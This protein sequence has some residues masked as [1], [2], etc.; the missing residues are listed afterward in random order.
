MKG[1]D[2]VIFIL[3]RYFKGCCSN[4]R[5]WKIAI[6][7]FCIRAIIWVWWWCAPH[8]PDAQSSP[9]SEKP[10]KAL[11]ANSSSHS[12]NFEETI[13][14]HQYTD[15]RG[16]WGEIFRSFSAFSENISLN[17]VL[18]ERK[19]RSQYSAI[20]RIIHNIVGNIILDD[21]GD[22]CGATRAKLIFQHTRLRDIAETQ[23]HKKNPGVFGSSENVDV[24]AIEKI[25]YNHFHAFHCRI[26]DPCRSTVY[27]FYYYLPSV[28]L[29]ANSLAVWH[30][31]TSNTLIQKI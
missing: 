13:S 16:Q 14:L 6:Q 25:L 10:P 9:G 20:K 15:R 17:K 1:N 4:I 21:E 2:A 29:G 12:E 8:S 23:C 19:Q 18:T 30:K 24:S 22:Y 7:Y 27:R 3:N 28:I 5:N 11:S 31:T 26:R